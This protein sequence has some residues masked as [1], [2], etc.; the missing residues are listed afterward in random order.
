[1]PTKKNIVKCF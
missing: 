1:V